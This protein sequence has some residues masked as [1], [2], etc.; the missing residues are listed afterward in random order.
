M[1]RFLTNRF[2][3]FFTGHSKGE[4]YQILPR[5]VR[6]YRCERIL[7]KTRKSLSTR[8]M[9]KNPF[10][11]VAKYQ[12]ELVRWFLLPFSCSFLWSGC[13]SVIRIFAAAFF[14]FFRSSLLYCPRKLL[15]Y[16][17]L[18][19]QL[20]MCLCY[21]PSRLVVWH[22][23]TSRSAWWLV[24]MGPPCVQQTKETSSY[25]INIYAARLSHGNNQLFIRLIICP[26]QVISTMGHYVP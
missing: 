4:K 5:Q 12:L 15:K 7:F 25:S 26:R 19:K 20:I 1:A 6:H 9:S 8:K 16:V 23:T 10:S 11:F 22:I 13:L 2:P 14:I 3:I 17:R 24:V 18:Y 21:F